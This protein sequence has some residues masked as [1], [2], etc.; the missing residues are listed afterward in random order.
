[1]E[2]RCL[3][4]DSVLLNAVSGCH[5]QV[6]CCRVTQ[7]YQVIHHQDHDGGELEVSVREHSKKA[8]S[9]S[10]I[11]AQPSLP[12]KKKEAR[13]KRLRRYLVALKR[14]A[15]DMY[16]GN[17]SSCD[18]YLKL[19]A[20]SLNDAAVADADAEPST[21]YDV[22]IRWS[23]KN[24]VLQLWRATLL[25][26]ATQ[27]TEFRPAE[28]QERLKTVRSAVRFAKQIGVEVPE[29]VCHLA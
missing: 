6:T 24:G 13:L 17:I 12:M 16:A 21:A 22:K 29:H 14:D 4:C 28:I 3:V 15:D 5:G 19:A 20:R 10:V 1:M 26:Y 11:W 27:K 2:I 25:M 8:Y 7:R 18:T 23:D 9:P